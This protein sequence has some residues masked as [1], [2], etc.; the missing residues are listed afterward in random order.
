MSKIHFLQ[1][2]ET[3][4]G[5]SLFAGVFL[6]LLL[7]AIIV[8]ISLIHAYGATKI[9]Q[10][11]NTINSTILRDAVSALELSQEEKNSKN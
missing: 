1:T 5:V 8:V 2:K 4:I 9:P 6:L 10:T 11:T 7:N 3:A